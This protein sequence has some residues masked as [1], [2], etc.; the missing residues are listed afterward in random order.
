MIYHIYDEPSIR[1]Q[2]TGIDR[3]Q[4]RGNYTGLERRSGVEQRGQW[5]PANPAH[6]G[7]AIGSRDSGDPRLWRRTLE[8]VFHFNGRKEKKPP[9]W[10]SDRYRSAAPVEFVDRSM[11]RTG[12]NLDVLIE[13]QDS[14]KRHSGSVLNYHSGGFY[15]ELSHAIRKGAGVVVT[16]PHY[17]PA[18]RGPERI[19]SYFCEVRWVRKVAGMVAFPRYG[20]GVS[21]CRD[22]KGFLRIFGS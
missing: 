6:R 20:I 18:S 3:R 22:L 8:R 14:H 5:S 13:D 21:I 1:N 19:R 2:R 12:C 4:R 11:T 10:R 15:L 16:F 7:H 17:D 9:G